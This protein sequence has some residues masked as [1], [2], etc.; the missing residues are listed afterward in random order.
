MNR[1]DLT[2]QRMGEKKQSEVEKLVRKICAVI[3]HDDGDDDAAIQALSFCLL[4]RI[5][6]TFELS[7]RDAVDFAAECFRRYGQY[8]MS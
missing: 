8:T 7:K 1:H 6:V 4:A 3:D 5:Q 2:P